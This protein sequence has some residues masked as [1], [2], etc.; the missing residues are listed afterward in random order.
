MLK[1]CINLTFVASILAATDIIVT[2]DERCTNMARDYI[3]YYNVITPPELAI[4]ISTCEGIVNPQY[5]G[6]GGGFL[7]SVFN[8]YCNDSANPTRFVIAREKAPASYQPNAPNKYS[9]I[10]VPSMLKGYERLYRMNICG[11]T[12]KIAWAELFTENIK[13]AETGWIKTPNFHNVWNS[14][15]DAKHTFEINGELVRNPTLA[16]TLSR[17]A[18]EGPSSSLYK[19]GGALHNIVV[20]DLQNSYVSSS[21]LVNYM[22]AVR[23]SDECT[24]FNYSIAGANLPGSGFT[25]VLGCRIVEAAYETLK[26]LAPE[27]RF[28]FMYHVL[29]YMY[30]LKPHL[31]ILG[32]SKTFLLNNS[33]NIANK[34]LSTF[35]IP[36]NRDPIQTFGDYNLNSRAYNKPEFG[37][38][39]IIIK[40]G[41]FAI[42][43]TSTVNS[44]WGSKL[45]SSLGFFYNNQ[46]KDFDA[47]G[48]LNEPQPNK[49]PQ[50]ATSAIIFYSKK[51]NPVF[52]IGAA[53][54]GKMIGAIFNTFFN[55]FVNGVSLEQANSAP[56]CMPL[57]KSQIESIYC[58]KDLDQNMKRKFREIGMTVEYTK[59]KF[60]GVTAS[61]TMRKGPEATHDE[62][63]GGQAWINKFS[64]YDEVSSSQEVAQPSFQLYQETR[65]QQIPESAHPSQ[66]F[67]SGITNQEIPDVTQPLA[68]DFHTTSNWPHHGAAQPSFSV[69]NSVVFAP[70]PVATPYPLYTSQ[71]GY[72]PSFATQQE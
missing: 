41:K 34:I 1:L 26:E 33:K 4:I 2:N 47:I 31:K 40:R 28:L 18:Q 7:M 42:T 59:E 43:M 60:G 68:Q 63:R 72:N 53:G 35:D 46:L 21:D 57:Y 8:G 69:S 67:S 64:R 52:Q 15:G 25:F 56:R 12:P 19:P 58:E 65:N 48:T 49:I 24:C 16:R 10:G 54:G 39:N 6:L 9:E 71:T 45:T 14:L 20:S 27:D 22:A 51:R 17:I 36:W 30:S 32:I 61:S 44:Y 13:L 55:Y 23:S 3:E 66:Q 37:T 70:Y 29:R 5:S 62:R 50:S 11:H 38:A